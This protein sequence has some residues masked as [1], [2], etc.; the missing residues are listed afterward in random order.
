L[1]PGY[2]QRADAAAV[3]SSPERSYLHFDFF[4]D[5]RIF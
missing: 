2:P 3:R 4:H 1:H 5:E